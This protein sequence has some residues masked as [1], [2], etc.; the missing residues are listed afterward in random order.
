V[1]L[2]GPGSE[3]VTVVDVQP[4]LE[5]RLGV[6]PP[7]SRLD[8]P[9]AKFHEDIQKAFPS[10]SFR[11]GKPSHEL[12]GLG[13]RDTDGRTWARL[14]S[15]ELVDTPLRDHADYSGTWWMSSEQTIAWASD[16]D[17]E[18]KPLSDCGRAQ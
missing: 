14:V 1:T 4:G 5:L 15:G 10:I 7:C 12:A 17:V 6:L 9:P 18:I 8:V 2:A 13:F 11:S 3:D 16:K